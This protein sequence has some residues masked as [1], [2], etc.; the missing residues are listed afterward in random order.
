MYSYH[1]VFLPV[2]SELQLVAQGS[3][4]LKGY[5]VMLRHP[6]YVASLFASVC[7]LT[8]AADKGGIFLESCDMSPIMINIRKSSI[9]DI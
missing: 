4:R 1:T 9:P 2:K 6:I 8:G 7:I 3:L 5:P